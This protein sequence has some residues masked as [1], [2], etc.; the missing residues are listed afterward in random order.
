MS[1]SL[2][3]RGLWPT[4]LLCPWDSPG[5]NTD[6]HVTVYRESHYIN[7]NKSLSEPKYSSI[8]NHGKLVS[9]GSIT[10]H[11]FT[12]IILNSENICVL[13]V[14]TMSLRGTSFTRREEYVVWD[15]VGV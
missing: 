6:V 9:E 1:D 3:P 15:K 13:P 14:S 10:I 11:P 12:Y 7:V 5:R 2:R 4:R 8:M